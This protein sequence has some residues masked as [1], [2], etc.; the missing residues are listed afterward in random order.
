MDVEVALEHVGAGY[1]H[2]KQVSSPLRTLIA[3]I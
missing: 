3:A 1:R 2:I